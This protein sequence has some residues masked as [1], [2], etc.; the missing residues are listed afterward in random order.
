MAQHL[1]IGLF[2][3]IMG[4]AMMIMT[5]VYDKTNKLNLSWS[6]F[7]VLYTLGILLL[8]TNNPIKDQL[9]I[10]S[11]KQFFSITS[12]IILFIGI[13]L[14]YIIFSKKGERYIIAGVLFSVGVHFIPFDTMYTY[15]L[16]IIIMVNA[17]SVFFNKNRSIIQVCFIDA[18]L[19][20]VL[21]ICLIFYL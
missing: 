5:V 20:I 11:T 9:H 16:A 2:L 21:G 4:F 7:G 19:K 15:I 6:C 13:M 3:I 14:S 10:V 1:F 18:M 8:F 17:I 12:L